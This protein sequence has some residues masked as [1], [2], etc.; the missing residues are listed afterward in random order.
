MPFLLDVF[1]SDEPICLLL[2][3]LLLLCRSLVVFLLVKKADFLFLLTFLADNVDLH[4]GLLLLCDDYLSRVKQF[5]NLTLAHLITQVRYFLCLCRSLLYEHDNF[6][7][8]DAFD[9]VVFL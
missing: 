4:I 9:I 2:F 8:N 6:I 3:F 5:S 1:G 7:G